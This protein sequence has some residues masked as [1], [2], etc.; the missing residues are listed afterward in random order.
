MIRIAEPWTMRRWSES[1]LA[2]GKLLVRL[3]MENAH[4]VDLEWTEEEQAKP[5]TLAGSY[6]LQGA[7]GAWRV[8]KWRLA[9][10]SLVLGDTEDQ[11]DI[12]A[13]W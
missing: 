3:P 1:K 13:Q 4:I 9:W 8:H 10:Y 11:Y 7:T 6:T 2:D 5:M 12:S